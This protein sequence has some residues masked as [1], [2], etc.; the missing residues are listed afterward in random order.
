MVNA[1]S[2]IKDGFVKDND[3]YVDKQ[4]VK[5]TALLNKALDNILSGEALTHWKE[6]KVFCWNTL[7]FIKNQERIQINVKTLFSY[8][9]L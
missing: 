1:Y 5:I 3:K 6:K 4:A 8:F 2:A 9:V 7:S